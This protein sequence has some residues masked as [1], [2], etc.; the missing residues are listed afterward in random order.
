MKTGREGRGQLILSVCGRARQAKESA[1][2]SQTA[3]ADR[4]VEQDQPDAPADGYSQN[5]VASQQRPHKLLPIKRL[6]VLDPLT[7][8]DQ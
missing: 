1:P 5:L 7:D 6:Q 2:K 8:T 3:A 4:F